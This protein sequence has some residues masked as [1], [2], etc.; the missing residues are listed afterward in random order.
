MLILLLLLWW[1]WYKVQI[2]KTRKV[3]QWIC[4]QSIHRNSGFELQRY[5]PRN[6][7]N[8]IAQPLSVTPRGQSGEYRLSNQGVLFHNDFVIPDIETIRR[9]HCYRQTDATRWYLTEQH[10]MMYYVVEWLTNQCS[11]YY[12]TIATDRCEVYN[13]CSLQMVVLKNSKQFGLGI[14]KYYFIDTCKSWCQNYIVS[15]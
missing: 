9:F 15:F 14:E 3:Y 2:H 12:H 11:V 7:T 10:R 4:T 1:W 6:R 8:N 5:R 13:F